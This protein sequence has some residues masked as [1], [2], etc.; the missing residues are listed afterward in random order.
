VLELFETE[1]PVVLLHAEAEHDAK[2]AISDY[3]HRFNAF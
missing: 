3:S 1:Q 2:L